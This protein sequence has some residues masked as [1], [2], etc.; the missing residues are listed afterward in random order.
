MNTLT[1]VPTAP[2]TPAPWEGK[3]TLE[4]IRARFDNDVERF[5]KLET[6]QQAAMDSPLALELVARSAATHLKPGSTM[7][8]LGC[9]AGNF[10]LRVLQETGPLGCHLVDLSQPMLSRAES[11]LRAVG[12]TKV[13]THQSDLRK[14]HF[15][16]HSFDAILA[17]AVL[18][19]LR[20]DN[21]WAD[22]FAK[23]HRWLRP[24]GRLYVAD[25]VTFD[26]PGVNAMMW[27]RYGRYLES[28]G[29]AAYR[30]KVF[31]YIAQEDSPRSLP[32]Q[33]E[34]LRAA[35]FS[36]WDVLHR[37]SVFACYYG[38]K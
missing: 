11:R 34:R 25:L 5:S 33:L 22:V 36:S 9:G 17:G 14:L 8:D 27:D 13:T 35:G 20:D 16:G 24:G 19:H 10:T 3:S 18:H 2:A 28:L 7:L 29:G 1:A 6:G 37:N 15:A 31:G 23:M 4:E 32:Y 21:D 30:E 12:V 26:D 38:V